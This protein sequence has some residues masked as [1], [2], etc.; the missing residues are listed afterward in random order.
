[1]EF[2]RRS[3]LFGRKLREIFKGFEVIEIRKM[4]Q[5]EQPNTMFGESF[6]WAA[7]FKKK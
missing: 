4:E 7:L 5:I 2:T 3:C 1:M 6:L